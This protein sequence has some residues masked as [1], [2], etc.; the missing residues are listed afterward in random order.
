M[1]PPK[2]FREVLVVGMHFRG[3]S[4]REYAANITEGEALLI[5]REPENPYDS[6]AIK[7]LAPTEP[8][9]QVGYISRQ[10]AVW[11]ADWLDKGYIYTAT[12][13]DKQTKHNNIHP[14]LRL[15][16]IQPPELS[17]VVAAE[18]PA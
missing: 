3:E 9:F 14:I 7:V 16:L 12:V 5:E 10:D 8:P 4:A 6:N 1:N 2:T 11:I 13:T 17:V 15:D 18:E